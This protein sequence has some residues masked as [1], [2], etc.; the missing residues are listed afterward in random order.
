MIGPEDA[1]KVRAI[2]KE[3]GFY[4][5]AGKPVDDL[6]DDEVEAVMRNLITVVVECGRKVREAMAVSVTNIGRAFAPL[7]NDP[8]VHA[9]LARREAMRR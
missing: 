9:E 2:F 6:T 1:E 7:A 4:R 5:I 8:A 3:N